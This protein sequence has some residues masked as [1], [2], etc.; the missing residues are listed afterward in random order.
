MNNIVFIEGVSG[1]GK[2]TTT[3]LLAKR[4]ESLG[5]KVKCHLEGANNNPLDPF[6]GTYPPSM[7][8]TE[9]F[10]TYFQCW[11]SFIEIKFEC[12]FMVVD[13]TLL[14]HQIND[15]I[16]EY[17]ASDDMIAN[18][19]TSLLNIIQKLNPTIFYFSSN[20]VGQRLTQAR[21]SRKQSAPTKERIKFWENR[22]RVDLFVLERLPIKSH[23]IDVSNGWESIPETIVEYI[24][25]G[26]CE[27]V[28]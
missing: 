20:N 12:N 5:Y 11:Q 21:K 10:E 3:A 13:G 24:T 7:S 1:V 23:I 4:L 9:F 27:F 15:L 16:R 17:C 2:T 18:Y 6:G 14:H 19:L 28:S 26:I 22:K 25:G 8:I